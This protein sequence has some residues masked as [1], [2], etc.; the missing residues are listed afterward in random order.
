[1]GRSSLSMRAVRATISYICSLS[2]PRE[3]PIAAPKKGWE[4]TKE[5]EF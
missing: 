5:V 4:L 3:P 2:F 1:M